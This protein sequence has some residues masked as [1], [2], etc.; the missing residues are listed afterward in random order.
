MEL[1][2]VEAGTLSGGGGA[3]ERLSAA[4]SATRWRR[5]SKVPVP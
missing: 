2:R 3:K 4:Y 5:K 1:E